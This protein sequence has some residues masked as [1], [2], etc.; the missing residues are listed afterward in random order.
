[1]GK[2]SVTQRIFRSTGEIHCH[3]KHPKEKGG[4]DEY[5]NLTLVLETVHK[6]IHAKNKETINKYLKIIN[7]RLVLPLNKQRGSTLKQEEN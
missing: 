4:G 7:V 6:L 2:C 1:M 5:A 3:H